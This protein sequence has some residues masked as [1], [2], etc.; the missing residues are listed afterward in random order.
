MY[1][2]K[3]AVPETANLTDAVLANVAHA[4][5]GLAQWG[6]AQWLAYAQGAPLPNGGRVTPRSGAYLK[7]IKLAQ[8][9]NFSYEVFSDSPYAAAIERGTGPRDLKRMLD[10]SLKV[11]TTKDGRRYLIIPFRWGTGTGSG[12]GISFGKQVMPASVYALAKGLSPSRITGQGMRPSGTGASDIKTRGPLMV[13]SRQYHW[14]GRLTRQA[15]DGAGVSPVHAQRMAGMVKMQSSPR[16]TSYMTFRVMIEGGKGW[17]VP[18]QAGKWP[19]RTVADEIERRAPAI[20][21]AAL[22]ADKAA[23]TG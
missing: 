20:L 23:V 5:N 14:G 2:V 15:L 1:R 17:M 22:A 13:P 18:A 3:V 6:H 21:Q 7:S 19:A 12:G 8:T 16:H 9:G 4:I 11:R 10:S